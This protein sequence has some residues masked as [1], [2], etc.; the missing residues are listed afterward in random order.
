MWSC[1]VE[2]VMVLTQEICVMG[3]RLYGIGVYGEMSHPV[4][5][6]HGKTLATATNLS[7]TTITLRNSLLNR[8]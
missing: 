7:G 5:T 6:Y 4:V 3:L 2:P 8:G 1:L